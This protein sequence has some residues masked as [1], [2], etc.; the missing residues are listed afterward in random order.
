VSK[1]YFRA[2]HART[3]S[4]VVEKIS[5]TE[6][7]QS[8]L[9]EMR[10]SIEDLSNSAGV[11]DAIRCMKLAL[12][13]GETGPPLAPS[14]YYMKSPPQQFLDSVA[15]EA[16]NAFIDRRKFALPTASAAPIAAADNR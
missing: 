10:L 11:I 13:R 15:L 4:P 7:V 14:A 1:N 12:E 2:E 5:K 16:C 3:K 9:V 8:Q 6:A